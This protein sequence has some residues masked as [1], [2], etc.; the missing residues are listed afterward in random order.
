MYT[1]S[2]LESPFPNVLCDLHASLV[3]S[4]LITQV[5]LAAESRSKWYSSLLSPMVNPTM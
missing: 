3:Q 2:V 1:L 4:L 5:L